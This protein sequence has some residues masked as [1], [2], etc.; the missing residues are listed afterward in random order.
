MTLTPKSG[1]LDIQPY[2]GGLSKAGASKRVIK[3]SSNETPLGA[4]PKAIESYKQ[5]AEKLHRYPDGGCTVLREAIARVHQIDAE[6]VV[7]GAGSDEIISLLCNAY[8]GEGDEVLYSR[9]GF[10]MYAISAKAAGATPVTAPETDLRADVDA[11]LDAVTERT[12]IVFLANPNNP[13]G[14]YISK[15]EVLKLRKGL[16]DDILLVL[17][18]AYAEYVNATDYTSGFD[19]VDM[20]ENTVAT[21]TFSKIYGLAALRV[22]WAYCPEGVADI[23]NRVRGP[24]NVSAPGIEAAA[25]AMLDTS[26]TAKAKAHN[27]EWLPWLS[28]ELEA[29][30]LHVYPSQGNF[31]LVDF[32]S[33]AKADAANDYLMAEGIIP[34][35][36]V[37]YELPSCLRITIGL[38][39]DNQAVV[40]TLTA[41]LKKEQVA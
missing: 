40:K 23:L 27:D 10:L 37:N 39:S 15:N 28:Q 29:L 3:L 38:K 22:G 36:V 11:L 30:G 2:K 25:T 35:K 32:G 24:F 34:R 13:T 21:F 20:G 4:S 6:R 17:D 1:I 9:H 16:R 31:I 26:F 14:S 7:C 5:A 8:A 18:G 12:K 41:F 19:V 33:A